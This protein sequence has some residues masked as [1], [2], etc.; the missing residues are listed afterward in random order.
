MQSI[1]NRININ[2]PQ[3]S[4]HNTAICNSGNESIPVAQNMNIYCMF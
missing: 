4:V 3:N 1:S 2:S